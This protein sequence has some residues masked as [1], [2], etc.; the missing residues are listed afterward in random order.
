MNEHPNAHLFAELAE[1]AKTKSDP[2]EGLQYRIHSDADWQ[3]WNPSITNII[4]FERDWQWRFRPEPVPVEAWAILSKR[5]GETVDLYANKE[6]A[7]MH[8]PDSCIIW[9]LRGEPYT[10][11]DQK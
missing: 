7:E 2:Y 4:P 6:V 8:C 5:T 10:P 11:E 1:R 9:A 3:Q